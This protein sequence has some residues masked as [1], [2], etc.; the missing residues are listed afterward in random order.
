[1][2]VL[3]LLLPEKHFAYASINALEIGLYDFVPNFHVLSSLHLSS[4]L[5]VL[6][7]F[8]HPYAQLLRRTARMFQFNISYIYTV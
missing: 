5:F 4:W 1:M 2:H 8:P 6:F 7:S 3:L